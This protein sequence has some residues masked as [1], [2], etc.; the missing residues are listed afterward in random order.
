MKQGEITLRHKKKNVKKRPLGHFKFE[1]SYRKKK[2]KRVELNQTLNLNLMSR[3]NV[4]KK[5]VTF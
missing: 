2:T 1:S 5:I 4:D 3:L